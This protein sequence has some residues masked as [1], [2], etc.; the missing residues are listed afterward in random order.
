MDIL[1]EVSKDVARDFKDHKKQA[2]N[3]IKIFICGSYQG[4]DKQLLKDLRDKVRDKNGLDIPGTFLLEDIVPKEDMGLD[5]KFEL[6]WKKINKGDF[7][8]LCILYA[9]ETTKESQGVNIEIANI[10]KDFYK[11]RRTRIIR[12]DNIE[13]AHQIKEF[14]YHI[15]TTIKEFEQTAKRL[16]M[17]EVET[18]ISCLIDKRKFGG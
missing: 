9:G 12:Y 11:K 3:V 10:S 13:A 7:I 2:K 1:D 18:I 8:P 5:K 14:P 17:A 16:I 6:V 15:I 4:S